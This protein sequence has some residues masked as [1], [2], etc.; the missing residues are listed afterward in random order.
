MIDPATGWFKIAEIPI[1]TDAEIAFITEKT[2]FTSYPLPQ[3]TVFDRE[4]EFMAKFA[5]ICHNYY[6]LKRKN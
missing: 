4:T 5:K 2:W 3:T 1:R 6:G